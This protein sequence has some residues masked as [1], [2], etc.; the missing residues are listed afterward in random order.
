MGKHL[1]S[2][3]KLEL[4]FICLGSAVYPRTE[5]LN[6]FSSTGHAGHDFMRDLASMSRE[7][8]LERVPPEYR[9]R[10]EAIDLSGLPLNGHW[11]AEVAFAYDVESEAT[12]FIGLDVGRNYG[13]RQSPSEMFMAID[14]LIDVPDE[15]GTALVVD[16]KTGR[17]K[18]TPPAENWQLR[19]QALAVQRHTGCERVR[20]ALVRLPEDGEPFVDVAE[21]DTFDLD[22]FAA[23]L[24]ELAHRLERTETVVPVAGEHCKYCP[25]FE[26]CPAQGKL[27]ARMAA[28]PEQLS[29]DIQDALTPEL[30][31]KAYERVRL[32]ESVLKRMKEALYSYASSN[33]IALPNGYVSGPS[34]RRRSSWTPASSARC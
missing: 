7:E 16:W 2:A 23:E 12:R 21:F 20:V 28:N 5:R 30:A 4:A 10:C 32:V 27:I 26:H 15:P 11:R 29:G 17:G 19:V 8:A 33:P 24:R 1:P 13:P 14:A 22:L 6:P 31:A 3:S 34:R 9:A 25:A 18:L